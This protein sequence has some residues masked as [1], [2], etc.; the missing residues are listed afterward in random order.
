LDFGF[1]ILDCFAV[2]GFWTLVFGI[3]SFP[4]HRRAVSLN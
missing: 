2:F 3:R 4:Q 1:W